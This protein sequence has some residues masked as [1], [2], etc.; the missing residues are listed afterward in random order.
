M[1]VAELIE[2]LKEFDP[3]AD[4]HGPEFL[5]IQETGVG[6]VRVTHG[7]SPDQAEETR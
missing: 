3:R 7:L 6:W 2:K 5:I 1:T 4:V